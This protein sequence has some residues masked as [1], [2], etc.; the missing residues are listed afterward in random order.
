LQNLESGRYQ[1]RTKINVDGINTKIDNGTN[2]PS[3]AYLIHKIST[4]T[5]GLL[6]KNKAIFALLTEEAGFFAQ[7]DSDS[8]P[9][10]E[11][12]CKASLL[13]DIPTFP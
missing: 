2:R 9:E 12:T 6:K 1:K 8:D 13:H 10:L 11:S 4:A 3:K 5:L 7:L